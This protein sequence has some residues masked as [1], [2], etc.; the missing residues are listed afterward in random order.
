[1]KIITNKSKWLILIMS[2]IVVTIICIISKWEG[3]VEILYALPG[4]WFFAC[5]LVD[6]DED[7]SETGHG[8]YA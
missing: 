3:D 6:F 4:M 1:M 8:G 5:I 2:L 7:N